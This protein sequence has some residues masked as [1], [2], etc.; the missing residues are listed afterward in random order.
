MT[1]TL[2]LCLHFGNFFHFFGHVQNLPAVVFSTVLANMMGQLF[3]FAVG[4]IYQ[5]YHSQNPD[6]GM[7]DKTAMP[8]SGLAFGGFILGDWMLHG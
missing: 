1:G 8:L 2:F 4:A 7:V 5:I 3:L 6:F